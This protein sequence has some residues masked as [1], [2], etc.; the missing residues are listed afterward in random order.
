MPKRTKEPLAPRVSWLF[1][2]AG[3]VLVAGLGPTGGMP[4][5]LGVSLVA[6]AAIAYGP[7]RNKAT[8][9]GG[10]WFLFACGIVNISSDVIRGVMPPESTQP[11]LLYVPDGL[12]LI[13]Y[14]L[15]ATF[16]IR[17]A[18]MRG[19]LKTAGDY[20]DTLLVSL[21]AWIVLWVT[22]VDPALHYPGV[23]LPAKLISA[24]YPCISLAVAFIG[25]TLLVSSSRQGRPA[26]AM[27]A[28]GF[29]CLALADLTWSLH[30]IGIDVPVAAAA[31]M[32]V[33]TFLLA[34]GG[35]LHPSMRVVTRKSTSTRGVT[36]GRMTAVGSA[37][38]VPPLVYTFYRPDGMLSTGMV[39][40][41]TA[42]MTVAVI[43]RMV[44]AIRSYAKV[45]DSLAWQAT[46]DPLTGMPNR[47]LLQAGLDGLLTGTRADGIAV[48]F[49][50]LDRFKNVNDTYGHQVGDELLCA[51]TERL[52][53]TFRQTDLIARVSG[54]EFVAVFTDVAGT[55]DAYEF[56][57]RV[58]ATFAEPHAL[59]VGPMVVGGSVGVSFAARDRNATAE[60]LLREADQAMYRSKQSGRGQ[61]TVFDGDVADAAN[62]RTMIEEHLA[63]AVARGEISLAY[64]PMIDP[65]T[66]RTVGFEALMRWHH[67][68]LG[69]VVPDEFIPVAE[70][71]GQ[72]VGLGRWA[73][74]TAVAQ[75]AAWQRIDADLTM[76][77]NVSARQ[78]RDHELVPTVLTALQR[79]HVAAHT[80][81]LEV[82]ESAMMHDADQADR[83]FAA[84]S[85][86][87]VRLAL[88]DFG[89]GYSSMS[90][91]RRYPVAEVKIHESFVAGL[92]VNRDDEAICRSVATLAQTLGMTVSGEGV[93]TM[94]QRQ[95]LLSLGCDKVQGMLYCRPLTAAEAGLHVGSLTP[96]AGAA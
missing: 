81:T 40:V 32:Y 76:S 42:A 73:I 57:Q 55:A 75:L 63:G 50:D 12:S 4:V 51:V 3:V 18:K 21:G 35:A 96:A 74:D 2:A 85:Q 48:M 47:A 68:E 65:A 22:I 59:S 29:T 20:L 13:S 87:G 31:P 33:F 46:H 72:I 93:E 49:F 19:L 43:L 82:T 41:S 30:R 60:D 84:L 94:L 58:L 52:Q 88:D 66:E 26:A 16:I 61:V 79:H 64:Q 38:L 54:D 95:R 34:A 92:G 17:M 5:L 25:V 80:I 56:G 69:Q 77:I 9:R 53:A 78:L 71:S 7:R 62:R 83:V 89:T 67:P 15:L 36:P 10:W 24:A 86:A 8:D 6:L 37:L 1:I 91:L 11:P 70:E 44:D 23:P 28:A 90:F 45:Q 27:L 14:G 39:A